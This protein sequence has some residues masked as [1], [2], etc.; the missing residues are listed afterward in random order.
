M[1]YVIVGIVTIAICIGAFFIGLKEGRAQGEC[2]SA[3]LIIF[4]L[5]EV[6]NQIL[7]LVPP[8]KHDELSCIVKKFYD[9]IQVSV[10]FDD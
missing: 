1:I 5:K 8:E 9:D 6:F 3:L 10:N 4:K 2:C 7:T